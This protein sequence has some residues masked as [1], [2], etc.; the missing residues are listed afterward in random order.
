MTASSPSLLFGEQFTSPLPE[1]GAD[2]TKKTGC[3]RRKPESRSLMAACVRPV[4]ESVGRALKTS[5]AVAG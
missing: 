5:V 3:D 4:R 1:R 2:A